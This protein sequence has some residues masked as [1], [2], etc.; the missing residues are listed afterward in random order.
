MT[1][2]TDTAHLHWGA[3]WA[4]EAG[5]EGW[6]TPEPDVRACAERLRGAGFAR[7]LDLGCGVGRHALMLARMGY[8]VEALDGAPEGL[9]VLAAGAAAEGLAIGR[10]EAL[11]TELPYPDGAFDYALAFNVIY[12]GDPGIVTR[13]IGEIARVLRPGGVFQGTMLSKRN[14]LFGVGQEVAPDTWVTEGVMDKDH[15]HFYCNAAELVALFAGFELLELRDEL[16]QKPGSWHW[17]MIAERR[18]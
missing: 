6:L 8:A 1:V 11:M 2:R 13:T 15:P 5:R 10:T 7:A 4:T 17:H 9:A 12:H 18:P 14:R 3:R 16:H